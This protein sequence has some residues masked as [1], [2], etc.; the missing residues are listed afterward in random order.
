MING[1][2]LMINFATCT[3]DFSRR[4]ATNSVLTTL[5]VK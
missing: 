3:D 5:A 1:E 4:K 2:R